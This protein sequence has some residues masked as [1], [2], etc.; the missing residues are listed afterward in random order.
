MRT[1]GHWI[2]VILVITIA[3]IVVDCM[4][5]VRYPYMLTKSTRRS[6][7]GLPIHQSTCHVKGA[8]DRMIWE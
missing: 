2:G 8:F 5:V 7:T 4:R 6:L 3:V 1:P